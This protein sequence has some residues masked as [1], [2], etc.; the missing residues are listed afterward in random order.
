MENKRNHILLSSKK[1]KK[2][3][4]FPSR[5]KAEKVESQTKLRV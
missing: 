5:I 2:K 4:I 3:C 1:K